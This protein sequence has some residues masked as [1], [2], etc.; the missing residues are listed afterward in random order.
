[1]IC[2]KWTRKFSSWKW[3]RGRVKVIS[4]G[5][6]PP[7]SRNKRTIYTN[8]TKM[9]VTRPSKPWCIRK[10]DSASKTRRGW[11]GFW[12]FKIKRVRESPVN[13][14]LAALCQTMIR[15]C[16]TM[17]WW[18]SISWKSKRTRMR[19]SRSTLP[20]KAMSTGEPIQVWHIITRIRRKPCKKVKSAHNP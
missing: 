20:M 2:P 19:R 1:M 8:L 16:I 12:R 10:R 15:M 9:I 17:I 13:M 18:L 7:K 3:I 4:I 14:G 6:R 11:S 5:L